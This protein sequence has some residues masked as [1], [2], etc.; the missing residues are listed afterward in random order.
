MTALVLVADPDPFHL[1]ALQEACEVAGHRVISADNG[2]AVLHMVARQRPNLVLMARDLPGLDGLEILRILRADASLAKT[3]VLLG[4]DKD[5]PDGVAPAISAGADDCVTR[6]YRVVEVQ[7]RVRNALR[8]RIAETAASQVL[9]EGERLDRAT[10]VGT[11]A[12]LNISL[13][14]E[15]MRAT[16]YRY[17]LSCVVVRIENYSECVRV[18]DTEDANELMSEFAVGLRHCL[19]HVDQVFRYADDEFALILPE[20]DETGVRVVLARIRETAHASTFWKE[21]PPLRPRVAL[22]AATLSPSGMAPKHDLVT[23]AIA[24]LELQVRAG[25]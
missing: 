1:R 4:T 25:R 18:L 13:N 5:D 6:P 17:A 21:A 19:R 23:E 2:Q 15:T 24:H 14:Y 16:R 10:G 11:L 8:L 20:T 7:Q 9:G 3:A 12:H 22:G